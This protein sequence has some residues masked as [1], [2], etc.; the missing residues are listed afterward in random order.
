MAA[1]G[2]SNELVTIFG[3]SGF[4]G[5]HTV[6]ALAKKGYRIR[7]A[8]R[9]PDLAGY[10]QPMGDVGQIQPVQANLRYP[11]SVRR[12]A[13]GAH[14]VINS[15]GILASGGAQTFKALHDEGARAVA[16]AAREA[17]ARC[18][19]HISAI[20]ASAASP[21]QYAR[22]KAAGEAAVLEEFP[23]AIIVRPSIVFGPEDDFFNRFAAMA[24]ISPALPLVGGGRTRFQPVFVGDVAAAIAHA[25]QGSGKPGEVYELG[26]PEVLSFREILERTLEYVGRKRGFAPLPFWLAK[27]MALATW[28][29][30]NAL[31]PLTY[32]QVRLLQSDNVVSGAASKEGRTLAGLGVATAQSIETIVPG[33]LERFRPKGQ[34]SHYR[35]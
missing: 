10:L 15:V 32:D 27:L 8:S 16:R 26:G 21:A 30:P 17:G 2:G 5:R 34:Y 3:G 29:L 11:D 20:G 33:Y 18:L 13:E 23:G 9:R 35:G 4:V 1:Q 22:T 24:R 31:R 7:A 6:R 19:V 25:V 12:A 14:I 28:P